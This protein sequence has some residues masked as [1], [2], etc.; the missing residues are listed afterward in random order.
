MLLLQRTG[1]QLPA[2]THTALLTASVTLIPGDLTSLPA[3]GGLVLRCLLPHRHIHTMKRKKGK[4]RAT[5]ILE[6][7]LSQC[8]RGTW[9]VEI[10]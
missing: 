5:E 8:L 4:K 2:H 7:G 1:V 9:K 6:G 3:S 10:S